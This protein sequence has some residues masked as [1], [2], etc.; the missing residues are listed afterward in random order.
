MSGVISYQS[1]ASILGD[2]EVATPDFGQG[3]VKYFLIL[4]C[5]GNMI[6]SG[7]F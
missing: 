5:T 4:S 1:E 6:E 3:I 2:C 7:D